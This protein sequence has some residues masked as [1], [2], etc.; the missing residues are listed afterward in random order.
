[1]AWHGYY[2]NHNADAPSTSTEQGYMGSTADLM[3]GL[4]FIFIIMVAFLAHKRNTETEAL[5]AEAKALAAAAEEARSAFSDPRGAV[6]SAIGEKI[7]QTLST[8]SID[9]ASGIISL[10]EDVLFDLGSSTLKPSAIPKLIE[11]A[12]KLD[13]VLP[14]FVANQ[15]NLRDCRNNPYGHEIET[16]FIEGHTDNVPMLRD[17]GNTKLSL[18]RAISVSNTLVR[19][20]KM[21]EYRN[22]QD[23]PLFSYSAYEDTRPIKGIEPSDGRNRRVDLRIVLAYRPYDESGFLEKMGKY[24]SR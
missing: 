17:G 2:R 6:T 9:P 18:D 3:V 15:K 10:P 23:L 1:M 14:C 22:H 21:V 24:L 4:L 8:V 12:E 16:I 20:T 5:A 19:G 7:R 11:V 13:S